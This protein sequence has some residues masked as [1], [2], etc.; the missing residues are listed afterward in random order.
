[1]NNSPYQRSSGFD[2]RAFFD[3]AIHSWSNEVKDEVLKQK[4]RELYKKKAADDESDATSLASRLKDGGDLSIEDSF[5]R[6]FIKMKQ[7]QKRICSLV[8]ENEDLRAEN[9]KQKKLI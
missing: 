5:K 1:M 3:T 2:F 8:K 7:A 6:V 4:I 9:Q